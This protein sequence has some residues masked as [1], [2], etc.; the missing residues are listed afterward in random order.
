MFSAIFLFFQ[1]RVRC[2]P[3]GPRR[4]MGGGWLKSRF[5]LFNL[6]LFLEMGPY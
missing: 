6:A 3:Q 5:P 1:K 4:W 2:I